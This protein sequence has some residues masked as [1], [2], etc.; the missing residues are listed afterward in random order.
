MQFEKASHAE[1]IFSRPEKKDI[2]KTDIYQGAI[3]T[4]K[5]DQTT[6]GMEK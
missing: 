5:V 3:M 1:E 4:F 2:R 6:K